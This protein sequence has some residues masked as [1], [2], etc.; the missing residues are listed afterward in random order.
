M[1][2][3]QRARRVS[4]QRKLFPVI[5]IFTAIC[6]ISIALTL[7][8]LGIQSTVRAYVAGEGMW[9]KAGHD[10]GFLLQ[11]YGRTRDPAYLARFHQAMEV[12]LGY[13]KARLELLRPDFDAAKV[14][15][16]LLQGR[17]HIDDIPGVIRMFRCCS[18]LGD[19]ERAVEAWGE[20]DKFLLNLQS[21]ANDLED[22]INSS[23]YTPERVAALLDEVETATAR[24]QPHAD[25]FTRALGDGERTLVQWLRIATV[26]VV[27]LLVM[28]GIYISGRIL[29]SIR[30]SEEQ[31]HLLFE[32]ANDAVFVFDRASG[33]TLEFNDRAMR[34]TGKSEEELLHTRYQ[35]YF[36]PTPGASTAPAYLQGSHQA[37]MR[38]DG[39]I[40]PVEVGGSTTHLGS[41]AVYLAIVR[42]ISERLKSE[43]AL[44]VSANAMANM[45]EGVV[46]TNA[47]HRVISVN[48]AFSVITGFDAAEVIGKPLHFLMFRHSDATFYSAIVELVIKTGKW[49]G[50]LYH[51]RK[52]GEI[53]PAQL[54]ISTVTDE[55]NAVSH[56]VNVFNDISKNKEYEQRLQHLAHYDPLTQLPNRATFHE[57]AHAAVVRAGDAG[58]RLA[59]L[60]IDLDGF[61]MVN[62]T[63]G[64]AAGDCLLQVAAGRIQD[65]LRQQ[66]I[67]GRLGG[68]E[69]TA[70]LED[71]TSREDTLRVAGKLLQVL[72]QGTTYA[73]QEIS[74]FA[75]IGVS[76][77]PD[78]GANL[79][80][81]LTHADTAMYEA[82]KRG[83]NNVQVFHPDM[84]LNKSSRMQLS[85]YLKHAIEGEQ[86]ELYYQPCITMRSTHMGSV[87]AL[88]RWHHPELGDI[89]P[90]IFIP[91][92]EEIGL[93]S[94]ITEWVLQTAC[95][96][97]M[98]WQA[99]GLEPIQIAV[100]I[101]PAN[102]WDAAL[103]ANIDR[104]LHQTGF[105]AE[106]LCLEIT[107]TALRNQE[108]SKQMLA[109]LNAMGMRL[110]IDDFGVGYSSLNYLKHFP[111]DYLKID[112]SFIARIAQDRSDAAITRAI[113]A[114][115]K[116]LDLEVIAEGVETAEQ[117]AFLL[118]EGCDEAQGYFF[119]KPMPA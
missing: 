35:D 5:L 76:F 55:H 114:L 103:P 30:E 95:A 22:E 6:V 116:S 44:R 88:L 45:A 67:V 40:V 78:D 9:S 20:G 92:A 56:F 32:T 81:L 3:F 57:R 108:K 16:G 11:L 118:L 12:P 58:E 23:S 7:V 110:A 21:L 69:F 37:D 54:S 13:R 115:A 65:C 99:V 33:R 96:Q 105:H 72:A 59:L 49:Q 47:E 79:Q 17:T 113:I 80:T 48:Q 10:A 91:L 62:D 93:I 27:G 29:Q 52:N 43:R 42:D 39:A 61:K 83:R 73:N 1:T 14:E 106:R 107:E 85:S 31:Y 98:R 111:V 77:F 89:P 84:T 104:I 102:F 68:D 74:T 87:E 90:D 51:Q 15:Q 63:Y 70:L 60:F 26:T 82:K 38:I 86:F 71:V 50:E 119:G 25:E 18:K 8:A 94:S 109:Q 46:I 36:V 66:D 24:V 117:G 34:L 101:S 53:Y 2:D 19:F 41:M 75:S 4:L 64:H 112:R 28:V 100:N 97:G